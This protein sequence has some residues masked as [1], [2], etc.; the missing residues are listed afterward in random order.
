MKRGKREIFGILIGLYNFPNPQNITPKWLFCSH[1]FSGNLN[2][3]YGP[4][5]CLEVAGIGSKDKDSWLRSPEF[6]KEGRN[7]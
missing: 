6:L 7:V 5:K 1:N 4:S 2:G 3:S